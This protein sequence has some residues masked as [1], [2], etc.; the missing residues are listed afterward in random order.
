VKPLVVLDPGHGGQDPGC[1]GHGLREKD[2]VLEIAKRTKTA[3]QVGYDLRVKLTRAKDV[4]VG[5]EQ[6]AELANRLQA[7]YFVSVHVNAANGQATGY[8]DYV[9]ESS[10]PASSSTKRRTAVHGALMETL[11]VHGVKDRGPKKA[12]FVVLRETNMAALLTENLFID[13]PADA[14]LLSDD[15]FL[16]EVAQAHATGIARA[17]ELEAKAA[18]GGPKS[19]PRHRRHL[20]LTSPPM[21]GPDVKR[22][23]RAL[24]IDDDGEYGTAT[25][26]AVEAA[27]LRLGFPP[28]ELKT[29]ASIE[30][31]ELLYGERP[32]PAR[33]SKRA[34]R[35]AR[36]L[37]ARTKGAGSGAAA[38]KQALAFALANDG[39]SEKPPGSNRGPSIDR[40]QRECG[41]PAFGAGEQGWPW[42]GVFVHACYLHGAGIDLD[43]RIIGTWWIYEAARSNTGGLR[44]V[45]L[46]QAKA[47]DL[48][49]LY[50]IG[51]HVGMVREDYAGGTLK[52][53][54][55]N[56]GQKVT[57]LEHD[58]SDVVAVVRVVA[59]SGPRGAG[60]VVR[61]V[62]KPGKIGRV[63]PRTRVLAEPSIEFDAAVAYLLARPHGKYSD[64]AVTR[65]VKL[66][67]DTAAAVGVDPL[68]AISQ[69]VV[70][71]GGLTSDWS[72][73]PRRNP[74]GI[75]VTGAPG[76][77]L[78][79][80][81]WKDAVRA[82]VGR[83]LAYALPKGA[84]SD[85]Q[86][87]LI[88]E[89]LAWRPLP[90]DRRGCASS[91]AGLGGTWAMG[92]GYP[93]AISRIA[94]EIRAQG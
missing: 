24:G 17:L 37:Q 57:Q 52:T 66:Y 68:L 79:F 89:A 77:G 35:F 49:L 73:A 50:A 15:A 47:G 61:P 88:A 83:L 54:E 53:I 81:T 42:C 51:K 87:A 13:N 14:A 91:L 85:E 82:H 5:L 62:S 34:A 63:T 36:S 48:V 6:R 90:D 7:D 43:N 21:T 29:G 11:A 92:K 28:S 20:A 19:P 86:R 38:R 40:W 46:A 59:G 1:C 18:T 10:G 70:E 12:D 76:V 65:I 26:R 78:S 55:G 93:Q 22:L 32:L 44:R 23:Q 16:T 60:P 39:V 75:G 4:F 56:A 72:R 2:I 71:T 30:F 58:P 64:A 31:L 33:Q 67:F 41:H 94:N 84:E 9:H 74:A 8:E 25:A 45:P 3:L 69:M 80:P 27:K